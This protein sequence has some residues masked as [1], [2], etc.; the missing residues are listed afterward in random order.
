M[1]S[2]MDEEPTETPLAVSVGTG[3]AL[4]GISEAR[5]WQEVASGRLPTVRIGKRR[6]ILRSSLEAWLASLESTP[7]ADDNPDATGGAS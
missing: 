5:L 4:A 1:E 3:A 2:D 6:L 7:V